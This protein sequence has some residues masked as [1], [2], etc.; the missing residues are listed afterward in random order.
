MKKIEVLNQLREV[1]VL[2][3]GLFTLKSGQ[4]S[5][6]YIDLR[7]LVSFPQLLK[8]VAEL[9][10][11][12]MKDLHSDFICGIPYNGILISTSISISYNRP[13]L[14]VRKERKDYGTKK[15]VEGVYTQGQS[16]LLIEDVITTGRS[17]RDTCQIL[18]EEGLIVNQ[19]ICFVLR[20][21]I[22]REKLQANNCQLH[23]VF[24]LQDMQL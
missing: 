7:R 11:N 10:W 14:L 23:S 15:Q 4:Q 6:L 18:R 17:V 20:E 12:Q 24:N 3:H 21:D 2:Q 1:Q 9:M 22:A 16:V 8:N 5:N 13:Q 19:V